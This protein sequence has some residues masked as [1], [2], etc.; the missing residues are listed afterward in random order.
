M[1]QELVAKYFCNLVKFIE[2]DEHLRK[3]VRK[4]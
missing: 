3:R 1:T 2:I 4:I